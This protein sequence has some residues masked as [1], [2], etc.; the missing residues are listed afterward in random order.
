MQH[1]INE[2]FG[3]KYE[4]ACKQLTFLKITWRKP[5]SRFERSSWL[6]EELVERSECLHQKQRLKYSEDYRFEEIY[7]SLDYF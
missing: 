3:T 4:D 1:F 7:N 5:V 6:R 2:S